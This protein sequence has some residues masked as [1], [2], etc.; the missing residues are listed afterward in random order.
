M[1]CFWCDF[2]FI[3]VP[4][5]VDGV[6]VSARNW[7]ITLILLLFRSNLQFWRRR[8]RSSISNGITIFP[9]FI[10]WTYFMLCPLVFPLWRSFTSLSFSFAFLCCCRLEFLHWTLHLP[11]FFSTISL[12]LC[13]T[14]SFVSS[15]PLFS[16]L[17]LDPNGPRCT[18]VSSHWYSCYSRETGSPYTLTGVVTEKTLGSSA[19]IYLNIWI[20]FNLIGNNLFLPLIVLTF[21]FS[22]TAKRH[23][24]LINL[25]MT[26][27][28]SGVFSLLLCVYDGFTSIMSNWTCLPDF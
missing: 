28:F 13:S 21:I 1:K 6:A 9:V 10:D 24:I 23:P 18:W 25:C 11:F 15:V 17:L 12:P 2:F 19:T 14:F 26:L 20:Y 4:E 8:L 16:L 27:I 7:N 3:V 5:P 22:K